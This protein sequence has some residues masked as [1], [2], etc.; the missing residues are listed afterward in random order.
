MACHISRLKKQAEEDIAAS[1]DRTPTSTPQKRKAGPCTPAKKRQKINPNN[2]G[3]NMD[4][5]SADMPRPL[6]D[7]VKEE[8]AR[9]KGEEEVVDPGTKEEGEGTKQGIKAES[10]DDDDHFFAV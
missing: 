1:D 7:L 9:I 10:D 5:A 4:A 8:I 2:E 3:D 6:I